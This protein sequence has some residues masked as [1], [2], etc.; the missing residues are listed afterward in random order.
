MFKLSLLPLLL[1]FSPGSNAKQ[2]TVFARQ[3]NGIIHLRSDGVRPAQFVIDYGHDVNGFTTY[4]VLNASGDISAFSIA[5]SETRA[6]LNANQVRSITFAVLRKEGL[7]MSRVTD[8][9]PCLPLSIPI[10]FN[11]TTYPQSTPL[12]RAVFCKA[13]FDGSCSHYLHLVI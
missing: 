4:H 7:T 13:E 6:M 11:T 5:H 8:Q 9:S 3:E 12:I 2:D 1:L 10:G